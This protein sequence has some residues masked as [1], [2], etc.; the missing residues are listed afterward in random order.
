MDTFN[1][2]IK[3]SKDSSGKYAYSKAEVKELIKLEKVYFA[4]NLLCRIGDHV[5]IG[6]IIKS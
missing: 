2:K 1:L 5:V 6:E 4:G 3:L